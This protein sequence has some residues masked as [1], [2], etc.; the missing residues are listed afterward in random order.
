MLKSLYT[1]RHKALIQC[2][3]DARKAAGMTQQALADAL[4]KPQSFVAKYETGERRLDVI[5]FLKISEI[6]N[7]DPLTIIKQVRST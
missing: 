6:L 2:M 1:E 7:A 4:G 3:I 5:E